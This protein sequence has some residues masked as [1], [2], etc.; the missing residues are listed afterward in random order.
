MSENFS[1]KVF[2]GDQGSVEAQ[3]L[4]NVDGNFT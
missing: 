4:V 1:R 3:H 2:K